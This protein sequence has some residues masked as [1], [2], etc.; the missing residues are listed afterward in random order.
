MRTDP[1]FVESGNVGWYMK[2]DDRI[3][4]L[5][6]MFPAIFFP[7]GLPENGGT[8]AYLSKHCLQY[9]PTQE[10]NE[11][12][13]RA[14]K[15]FMENNEGVII[16][17][18]LEDMCFYNLMHLYWWPWGDCLPEMTD[19]ITNIMLKLSEA[20]ILQNGYTRNKSLWKNINFIQRPDNLR[21]G[22]HVDTVKEAKSI[23]QGK[24]I[25]CPDIT[26]NKAELYFNGEKIARC[27]GIWCDWIFPKRLFGNE[28]ID[29]RIA[30]CQECFLFKQGCF[31]Q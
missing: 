11:H 31:I 18:I 25:C 1:H 10:T 24:V 9:C 3:V 27:C 30:D 5:D 28:K 13:V 7:V 16:E 29:I 6:G 2:V 12:E 15:F 21:I 14:L 17:K 26:V 19:K 22:F 23:S 20:G 8:C 4:F